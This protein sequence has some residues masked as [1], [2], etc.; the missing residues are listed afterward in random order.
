MTAIELSSGC[1]VWRPGD[2]TQHSP[3]DR[4]FLEAITEAGFVAF[5]GPSG[6]CGGKSENRTVVAVHRGR[7]TKWEIVFR[8]S[9]S[10]VVTTSTT[11]LKRMTMTVIAWLRGKMLSADENSVHAVAS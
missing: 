1:Q 6:L 11:D 10:D 4:L 2:A 9:D 3:N 8:E 5:T 7:G